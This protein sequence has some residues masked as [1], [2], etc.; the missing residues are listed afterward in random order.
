[1][2]R[3]RTSYGPGTGA[4]TASILAGVGVYGRLTEKNKPL[5]NTAENKV[6][7]LRKAIQGRIAG[8]HAHAEGLAL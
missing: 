6:K 7:K 5:S 3:K 8:R 1:M 2:D 4:C